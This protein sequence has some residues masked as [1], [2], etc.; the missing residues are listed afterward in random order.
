VALRGAPRSYWWIEIGAM[1]LVV[2]MIGVWI[3]RFFGWFGG[4]VAV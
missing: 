4:P 1:A 2:V 3:A